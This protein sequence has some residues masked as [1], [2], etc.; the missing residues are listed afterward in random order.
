M[1]G[2]PN[3]ET[4]LAAMDFVLGHCRAQG[5]CEDGSIDTL[6]YVVNAYWWEAP[7]LVET[8][9]QN[10]DGWWSIGDGAVHVF[11]YDRNGL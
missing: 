5:L 9:K 10:A 6:Y 3:R 2:R 8:A 1:N 4:A 7:R 11:R